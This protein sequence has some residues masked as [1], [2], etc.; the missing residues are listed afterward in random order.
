MPRQVREQSGIRMVGHSQRQ[1]LQRIYR[2]Y[3]G[4]TANDRELLLEDTW[5]TLLRLHGHPM[6]LSL[7]VLPRIGRYCCGKRRRKRSLRGK[8]FDCP[9]TFR[10]KYVGMTIQMLSTSPGTRPRTWHL[11]QHQ[12]GSFTSTPTLSLPNLHPYWIKACRPPLS[13]MIRWQRPP[14]TRANR[15]RM[16]TRLTERL[17]AEEGALRTPWMR[18]LGLMAWEKMKMTS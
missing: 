18:S 4:M 16:I 2:S 3:Q 12:M 10:A 15:L 5:A 17:V 6:A 13:S 8:K 14:A 7:S 11:S 1:R 9:A